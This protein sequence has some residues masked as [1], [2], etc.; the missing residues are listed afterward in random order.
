MEYQ[1][2]LGLNMTAMEFRQYDNAIGRFV[3]IDALAEM[4]Y[5]GSPY[6][7]GNNNPVYWADPTGLFGEGGSWIENLWNSS[8]S[9]STTWHNSG[10]GG[11]FSGSDIVSAVNPISIDMATGQ[12]SEELSEVTVQ[13]NRH[14]RWSASAI[15]TIQSHVYWTADA[16]SGWRSRQRGKAMDD[17]QSD[18]DWLGAIPLI[19]EPIDLLNAGISGARGNYGTAALS[20]AA[21]APIAG[22]GAT[23]FK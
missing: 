14:G 8:G 22:W 20:L 18:L 10:S 3:G 19:G 9:G 15:G 11:F 13:A 5:S 7:F 17:F 1:D 6:S 2:E 21:M 16:Y 23:A 4:S 12:V